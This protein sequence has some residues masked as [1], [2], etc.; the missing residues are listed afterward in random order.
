[1]LVTLQ[2]QATAS[3]PALQS[4]PDVISILQVMQAKIDQLEQSQHK[5]P[6]SVD[7]NDSLDGDLDEQPVNQWNKRVKK[8]RNNTLK[9]YFACSVSKLTQAEQAVCDDLMVH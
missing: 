2:G 3:V 8:N 1:M 6:S 9:K 4:N 5:H 7:N